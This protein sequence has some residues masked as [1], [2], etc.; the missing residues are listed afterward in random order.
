[1][2][3]NVFTKTLWDGRRSLLGWTLAIAAVAAM[4][5]SFWPTVNTPQMQAAMANY[6]KALLEA[7]N[8]ND[9]ASAAGYVGSSVYGLLIPLLVAVFAIAYGTRA[10]AGDEEAG[11][12]DLLLA[13]PVS[14][15]RTALQRF[16][17]LALTLVVI[18]AVL[19]SAML[20]ITGP[21]RL[22]GITAG[23]FAAATLQLMLFG[24]CLGALAFAI[25]AATGRRAPALGGTA[26]VAVLAYLANGVFPQLKGLA[27]TRDV[28][29][30]HWGVGGE[31]L[32]NGLQVGDSLLLLGTTVVLVALGTL[33]FNRRDIAV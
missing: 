9:L 32:K 29:P 3:R 8:Y 11:T 25:G 13:H 30:W 23:E 14:R 2:L 16:G 7:F 27:W 5:A 15:T 31:P 6:P 4:Y 19:W 1:V 22:D 10:V 21:A 28:S 20:A 12:L 17:A 26:G 33:A 18:G 24:A